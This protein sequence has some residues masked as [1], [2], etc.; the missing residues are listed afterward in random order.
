MQ[1]WSKVS[2]LIQALLCSLWKHNL[3][4]SE[5]VGIV[6]DG[7]PSVIGSKNCMLQNELIYHCFIHQQN[8]YAKALRLATAGVHEEV[9]KDEATMKTFGALKEQYGGQ[10]L[11]AGCH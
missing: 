6:T 10:H 9:P 3:G 11:A 8:L 2:D 4:L 5:L 7:A 1:G